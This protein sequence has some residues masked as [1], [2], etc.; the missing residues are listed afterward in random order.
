MRLVSMQKVEKSFGPF[1]VLSDVSFNISTGEK[2]GLIGPNGSGKTT[3]I[4]LLCGEI[5][6]D[7]GTV[8]RAPDT[9]IGHVRQHVEPDTDCTVLDYALGKSRSIIDAL[10]VAEKRLGESIEGTAMDAAI[11]AYQAAREQ[12]DRIQGDSLVERAESTLDSLGLQKKSAQCVRTLSGGEKNILS[13]A[14]ALLTEPDLLILDEPDNHLDF[15]GVA[16]LEAF[17]N[18]FRGAVLIISHNRYLLDRVV[19]GIF[20]LEGGTLKYYDGGYSAYRETRLRDLLAQQADY[21]ANQKRLEQLEALVKKFEQIARVNSDPAWG[22]RLRARRSQLE[23]EKQHAVEKPRGEREGLRLNFEAQQSRA[24]IALQL[25]KYSK[26]IG[27]TVLFDQADLEIRCGER[28]ALIGPNGCGKTTLLRD[29]AERGNWESDDIRIGP[30]LNVFYCA[31]EQEILNPDRTILE[32]LRLA[33]PMTH[34]GAARYM[35]RFQFVW[36][37][38]LKPIRVLSGGER[39]RMQLAIMM[40][41]KPNFLILD[42]PTNHLDIPAR[43]AVEEALAELDATVLVVSH[44][45]YLLD[46]ITTRVIDITDRRFESFIGS[47][48]EYWYE[49][50][51]R[52]GRVDGRVQTRRKQRIDAAGNT[53]QKKMKGELKPG[54]QARIEALIHEAEQ[55]KMELERLINGSFQK[56][57]YREGRNLSAKLARL[58]ERIEELYGQWVGNA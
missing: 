27:N 54:D 37:D 58:N 23:H 42:E 50:Q 53:S 33:A 17:L 3:V 10:G 20:H 14:S 32:E 44:D 18:R 16:W 48:S 51:R 56:S 4:R 52:T 2:R 40:L 34:D 38:L 11:E 47:F 43:E 46:K 39:N 5:D 12:Y 41:R 24:N 55:E 21:V 49:K 15:N 6:A 26:S 22:K 35:R 29:I 1:P 8:Y 25:R 7:S 31:Q 13:L 36:D 28:V 30:S 19:D 9:R 57:D 45:R